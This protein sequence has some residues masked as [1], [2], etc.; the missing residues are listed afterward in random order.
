M[1][2]LAPHPDRYFPNTMF[3]C[4]GR[5][6]A[7]T[8]AIAASLGPIACLAQDGPVGAPAADAPNTMSGGIG[9]SQPACRGTDC[10]RNA[11]AI[12][13]NMYRRY[14]G[15]ALRERIETDAAF[16]EAPFGA[17]IS[18]VVT[19][20]GDIAEARLLESSGDA[21]R[22]ARLLATIGGLKALEAPPPSMV[23][24]QA[25]AVRGSG[26]PRSAPDEN[27]QSRDPRNAGASEGTKGVK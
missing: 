24:P 1:T 23:F 18:I 15:N 26:A 25:I 9:A 22:D 13:Q 14:L 11:G 2:D 17:R 12:S 6:L 5:A 8:I 20:A 7:S 3:R 10:A 27:I 16:A 21:D 4:V 19:P